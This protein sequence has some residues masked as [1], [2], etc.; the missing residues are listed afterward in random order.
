MGCGEDY[1]R[2]NLRLKLPAVRGFIEQ[3]RGNH[4]ILV[5]GDHTSDILALCKEFDVTPVFVSQ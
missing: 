5:Y 4:H 1:C 3:V 2:S